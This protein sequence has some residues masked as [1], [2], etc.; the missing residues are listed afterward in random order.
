MFRA[1]GGCGR[2]GLLVGGKGT[3]ASGSASWEHLRWGVRLSLILWTVEPPQLA[4]PGEPRQNVFKS[5]SASA[6]NPPPLRGRQPVHHARKRIAHCLSVEMK[7]RVVAPA[8]RSLYA[9]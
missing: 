5:A 3:I 4:Q 1:S 6:G 8:D 9:G 7:P 2:A